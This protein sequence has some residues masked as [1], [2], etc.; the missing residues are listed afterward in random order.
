MYILG[1]VTP[2]LYGGSLPSAGSVMKEVLGSPLTRITVEPGSI[3]AELYPQPAPLNP[4]PHS[5]GKSVVFTLGSVGLLPSAMTFA[6]S[7]STFLTSSSVN[8]RRVPY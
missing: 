3:Q 8:A 4:R 1:T 2:A 5:C 7:P 6:S